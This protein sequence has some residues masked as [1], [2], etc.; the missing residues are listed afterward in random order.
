MEDRGGVGRHGGAAA[1]AD[2]ARGEAHAGGL[3]E[4]LLGVDDGR[5]GVVAAEGGEAGHGHLVHPVLVAEA[6]RGRSGDEPGHQLVRIALPEDGLQ[7]F[8]ETPGLAALVGFRR[9][10][11]GRRFRSLRGLGRRFG[12]SGAWLGREE[13]PC[14][15]SG[16]GGG[17][18]NGV[19]ATRR[20]GWGCG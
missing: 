11:A 13:A 14:G 5:N 1:E 19:G 10:L 7:G 16:G 12:W 17:H 20:R 18:G 9:R 6:R 3:D 15:G 4:R 8:V 2:E